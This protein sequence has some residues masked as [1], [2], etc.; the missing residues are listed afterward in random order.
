MDEKDNAKLCIKGVKECKWDLK[1]YDEELWRRIDKLRGWSWLNVLRGLVDT[2]VMTIEASPLLTETLARIVPDPA[3]AEEMV[4]GREDRLAD[5]F[6]SERER[7]MGADFRT[8]DPDGL[9]RAAKEGQVY[10]TRNF[11][12]GLCSVAKLVQ[13][14]PTELMGF[15][16]KGRDMLGFWMGDDVFPL[17]RHLVRY[18][19]RECC[20]VDLGDKD[21]K[22]IQGNRSM[23]EAMKQGMRVPEAFARWC[24]SVGKTRCENYIR[25]HEKVTFRVNRRL[26][27]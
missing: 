23:Y 11:L 16:L 9:L 18:R 10:N 27:K 24:E 3:L 17:D 25:G 19:C 13:G 1:C 8:G 20:G 4:C 26:K 14:K 2:H 7:V 22:R 21:V 12:K 15:G 5:Y 6:I